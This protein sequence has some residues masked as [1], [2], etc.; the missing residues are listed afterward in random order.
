MIAIVGGGITGLALGRELALRDREFVVLEAANE[1]GGV[2]RSE[3]KEGLLLDWGPQRARLSDPFAG[4]TDDL[5][6]GDQLLLAPS[7]LD[8][9]I[10]RDAR[11][12]RVPLSLGGFLA[13]NAV[14]LRG[15]LRVLLEPFTA[16]PRD[17]ES[18]SAFF[19]RKLGREVYEHVVGPLYGGLYGSDP[20]DMVVGLSLG[21]LLRG[22]GTRRSLL[23]PFL[24]RA[25]RLSPPP[26]CSFTDG[27]QALP[28]ALARSLGD[29][30]RLSTPVRA[31]EPRGGG[32]NVVL[33]SEVLAA[34]QVV[35]TVPARAAAALLGQVAPEAASRIASL[36]YNPLAV[37]CLRAET[38]L[39]GLGFQMSLAESRPLRGVTFN[40]SLFGEAGTSSRGQGRADRTGLYTAYLGGS[41]HGRVVESDDDSLGELAAAEF[42]RCTGFEA[43]PVAVARQ[44]MPAWDRSWSVLEGLRLPTGV[45]VAANWESRPGLAGRL[46]QARSLAADL[47][48]HRAAGAT[49]PPA[50]SDAS[51]PS[52]YPP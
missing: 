28:L 17:D 19:T 32:W 46:A 37:V 21:R 8:F 31:I 48:R 45:Q 39:R 42:H 13:S 7:D 12:R 14:S 16:G 50:R 2:I 41:T 33:D 20:K 22:M 35:L 23:R 40:H 27:M 30:I 15:R 24:A 36:R 18:V 44:S 4:L 11:L 29:R 9:F 1:P 49:A 25:G 6:L 34:E 51:R 47:D 38:S 5:G 43:R 10:C 3:R 52:Q 26:A